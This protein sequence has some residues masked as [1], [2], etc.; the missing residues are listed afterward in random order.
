MTEKKIAQN[1][2]ANND[3]AKVIYPYQIGHPSCPV[4][5]K[6]WDGEID[7]HDHRTDD[8]GSYGTFS[9]CMM[10]P[11]GIKCRNENRCKNCSHGKRYKKLGLKGADYGKN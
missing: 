1:N 8:R 7:L 5:G 11:R 3:S 6:F 10:K 9:H 4:P 2:G